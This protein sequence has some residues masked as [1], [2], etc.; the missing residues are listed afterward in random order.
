MSLNWPK[1]YYAC[2]FTNQRAQT[3]QD[4]YEMMAE[5][6]VRLAEKQPG[7]LGMESVRDEA[8]LGIIRLGPIQRHGALL[9]LQRR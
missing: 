6:M 8:G 5:Q 3:G 1:P 9:H 4:I 7:F 2:I